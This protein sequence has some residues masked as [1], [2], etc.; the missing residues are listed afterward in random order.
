LS[1]FLEALAAWKTPPW[2]RG[3][4]SHRETWS[5]R[6]YVPSLALSQ[7]ARQ[8]DCMLRG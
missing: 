7:L 8:L 2:S 1:V 3:V 5:T 6:L 4:S